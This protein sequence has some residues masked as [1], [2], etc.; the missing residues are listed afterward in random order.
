MKRKTITLSIALMALAVGL[1]VEVAAHFSQDR[2]GPSVAF[3]KEPAP[4]T[5]KPKVLFVNSYHEGYPWSDSILDGIL[6]TL[7]IHR[8][9]DGRL[10]CSASPVTLSLCYMDTKRNGAEEYKRQAGLRVKSIV[11]C[12]KPDLVIGSDDN[13]AKYVIVPYFRGA[14]LPFVFCG[15][16]WD[17][18]EYGLPC[19][20]VTGMLEVAYIPKLMDALRPYAHGSRVGLMGARN[21]T[22][23]KDVRF[24][25][26]SAGVKIEQAVLVDTFEQWKATYADLQ[27]KVDM[28]ILLPPSFIEAPREQAEARRFVLQNTRIPT[29]SVEEWIA[30]YSLICQAKLGDEQGEWTAKTAL[31]VLAGE[32]PKD[33]P[34]AAN[35]ETR[36]IL[37]MPLAK[38]LGIKFP[39]NLIEQSTLIGEE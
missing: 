13:Y 20:N 30:P 17:A 26:K 33:I 6:A 19:S 35:H 16:N 15:V 25:A 38:K 28:L 27:G 29:G 22:N 32:S 9:N 39:V 12:W 10:D 1:T 7:N 34:L 3:S 37:N 23:E 8:F 4:A 36:V 21:E 2:P 18:S 31:R 24:Y 11:E 14:K 5:N